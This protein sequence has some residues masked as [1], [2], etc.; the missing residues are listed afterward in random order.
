VTTRS[1]SPAR[2]QVVRRA[3][4]DALRELDPR[5]TSRR[6]LLLG[7][8]LA[9]ALATV[10]ATLRPEGPVV[11]TTAAI[12]ALVLDLLLFALFAPDL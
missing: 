10:F 4:L 1:N 2:S 6:P 12:W 7:T 11:A 3:L 5:V 9:A 8:S